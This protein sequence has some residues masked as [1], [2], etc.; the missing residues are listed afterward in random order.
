[1][2]LVRI[3]LRSENP[4]T[5]PIPTTM[6]EE[7]TCPLVCPLKGAG[8]YA[9]HGNVPIHWRAVPKFGMA[10]D[11]FCE[12]ISRLKPGSMWRHNVAGDLPGDR[13]HIDRDALGMLVDANVGKRGFTYTHYSPSH[14]DN[15]EAICNA[16]S[17]GFTVNMSANSPAHADTLADYGIGP[18][19][20]ILPEDA[21]K[22]SF[23][24]AGR[25]IVVCPAQYRDTNCSECGLCA[26][27]ERSYIIGFR[28]H[29]ARRKMVSRS[30]TETT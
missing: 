21:P 19:V 12:T 20:T 29:G 5:G 24:P 2:L 13:T 16:N 18:V 7:S 1:M 17:N 30:V 10:W 11:K 26:L 14:S 4:K 28:A 9:E 27:A 23:T 3:T 25:K 15:A 6:S 8:C 22:V